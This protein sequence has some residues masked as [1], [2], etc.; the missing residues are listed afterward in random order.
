MKN[1]NSISIG[2]SLLW[3]KISVKAALWILVSQK[4]LHPA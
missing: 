3:I 1:I 2:Y 4:G